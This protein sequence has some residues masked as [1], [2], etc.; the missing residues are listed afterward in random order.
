MIANADALQWL[1]SATLAVAIAALMLLVLP[2][3]LRRYFGAGVAYAAWWLVPAAL[4]ASLLPAA[5]HVADGGVVSP[6]AAT[7]QAIVEPVLA[8]IATAP[9]ALPADHGA[10]WLWIWLA[11]VV[12]MGLRLWMQQ[13]RFVRGLG[14]M[15]RLRDDLWKAQARHGL[16]ALL[17]VLHARIV[18][19]EDFELRFDPRERQLML[20]HERRHRSRGDHLANFAFVVAR[21][22][23]WFNPLVHLA[24]A[25]F[26]HDQELACDQAVIAAHPDSRRA[27]GEAMLKTLMADRQAPLGC[28]WGFS[29][30]LKERVMQLKTPAPRP[31]T[32]R[33]GVAIVATLTM[34]AGF[35]VWSAQPARPQALP[36]LPV[37]PIAAATSAND[38]IYFYVHTERRDRPFESP[39]LVQ[40]VGAGQVRPMEFQLG[41]PGTV[42]VMQVVLS[43]VR[44]ADGGMQADVAI[45]KLP[46]DATAAGRHVPGSERTRINVHRDRYTTVDRSL[47]GTDYRVVV[48]ARRGAAP[49]GDGEAYSGL[50]DPA[51]GKPPKF[52][53]EGEGKTATLPAGRLGSAFARGVSPTRVAGLGEPGFADP[54][55]PPTP[56]APPAPPV[57]PKHRSQA[58]SGSMTPPP[59]PP[60]P[61]APP[62]L[63]PD[64]PPPAPPAPKL[65]SAQQGHVDSA[66]SLRAPT[67]VSA[68]LPSPAPAHPAMPASVARVL[69]DDS[70]STD[71]QLAAIRQHIVQ[72]RDELRARHAQATQAEAVAP[73]NA[74]APPRGQ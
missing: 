28:H 31:W 55:P 48:M 57:P 20:A 8:P 9:S 46:P 59:P 50:Y 65:R 12:L 36:G 35:T 58:V 42:P 52:E 3:L 68:P 74:P 13:R 38:G 23:F 15:R 5:P 69:A 41:Y 2:R 39:Q 4:V 61:P 34:G 32:R 40:W 19:P 17:G 24:A 43:A 44:G 16:P 14:A 72:R 66:S 30:P 73:V 1:W 25:R 45:A 53:C 7:V 22:L 21:C 70:A 10:W 18:L 26:R 37:G 71:E 54:P 51:S 62:P 60:A 33:L 49:C 6:S 56:P 27:Y 11:G 67:P 63:P 29:H 64:A 47:A